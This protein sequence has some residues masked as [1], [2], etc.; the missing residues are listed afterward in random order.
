MKRLLVLLFFIIFLNA[1]PSPCLGDTLIIP[2]YVVVDEIVNLEPVNYE[3]VILSGDINLDSISHSSPR[4]IGSPIS[5]I[6]CQILGNVSFNGTIFD[7]PVNFEKTEFCGTVSFKEAEFR[8][9][10]NFSQCKFHEWASFRAAKFKAGSNF[11]RS[12]LFGFSTFK[13]SRFDG[14]LADFH[15][16]SFRDNVSFNFANFNV[17]EARFKYSNF[18][19]N[20][21]FQ[22]A[23]FGGK[24]NFLGSQF[25]GLADFGNSQFNLD[26]DFMGAVFEGPL[27][28]NDIKF[29]GLIIKWESIHN[30]LLSDEPGYI[31]LISNFRK[32]GQ[33]D[34]ADSCYYDYREWKRANRSDHEWT[35]SIWDF[36]AW[37]TCGYGVRWQNPILFGVVVLVFF[38]FYL[39]F[40]DLG[41][42]L[43]SSIRKQSINQDYHFFRRLKASMAFSATTLLSLPSEWYPFGNDEYY[44][45][46]KRHIC[47]SILERLIGW[48]LMLLLI[49]TITRLMVRY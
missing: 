26:S 14:S 37:L 30:K 28:V 10:S 2:S 33:F 34:D 36:I 3:S 20:A 21:N 5:I 27:K 45:L 44:R 23:R 48:G 43:W 13:N 6:D 19:C 25:K 17:D 12:V 18:E 1:L 47:C 15:L 49:G 24:A 29:N 4:L 8:K 11:W 7:Q 32:L 22:Q 38:G 42:F 46:L 9:Y 40:W 16:C 35:E 41:R 31:L 39:E